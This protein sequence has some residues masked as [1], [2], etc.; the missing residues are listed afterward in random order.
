[1]TLRDAAASGD[2]VDGMSDRVEGLVAAIGERAAALGLTVGAIES[3]TSGNVASALG[4]G[5]SASEWFGGAIVA[6]RTETK[7]HALS[8]AP[9]TDPYSPSCARQ[10]AV[11]G[12]QVLGVDVCVSV[13]G[14]GGP[15]PEGSHPPGEVHI[16]IAT[17]RGADTT[18]HLFEGTAV[19][20]VA[21]S[22][23]AALSALH[24]TTSDGVIAPGNDDTSDIRIRPLVPGDA[25]E[26]LT[27]QRAAFVSEAQIYGS[28]DS[29][30]LTQTLEQLEAEI[31]AGGGWSARLH[32]RLVGA[33]RTREADGVLL[34]GRIAIAPDVQ[35]AG[36]GRRLLAAAEEATDAAEA[37]LFTGSLSEANLRLY[38]ELGYVE[39][40]R[41]DQG[42]GTAQVFMR[43]RLRA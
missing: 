13:T 12:R 17:R 32:E 33:I 20:I 23:N 8:V 28:A 42:D 15:D 22:M 35:G 38:Q 3:L 14:V 10:L 34:V 24:E 4:R 5:D 2:I 26:L 41:I 6:Y 25:G 36:I 19:D 37:E 11:N 30:P 9:G 16:G 21:Q 39:T 40:E 1:M 29:G 43:K 27:V 7:E 31:A 18:S